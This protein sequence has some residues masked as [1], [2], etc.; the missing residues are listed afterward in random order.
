[1]D[2]TGGVAMRL[3]TAGL[4]FSSWILASAGWAEPIVQVKGGQTTLTLSASFMEWMDSCET[5]RIKPAVVKPGGELLRFTIAGGVI[6]L[7]SMAGELDH[8]GGIAIS[9]YG[10]EPVVALHNLKVDTTGDTPVIT[11]MAVVDGNIEGRLPVFVPTGEPDVTLSNWNRLTLGKVE[12]LLTDDAVNLLNSKLGT[13]IPL[14]FEEPIGEA[15][16]KVNLRLDGSDDDDDEDESGDAKKDKKE[17]VKKDK[18][19]DDDDNKVEEEE[20]EEEED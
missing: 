20:E 3:L 18:D 19:D 10:G 8:K 1:M 9:C 17:K 12:L 5:K 15:D 13:M 6:D 16:S 4:L 14:P 7:G 11:A 2:F